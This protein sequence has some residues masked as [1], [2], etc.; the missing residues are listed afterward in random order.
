MQNH[1]VG[2]SNVFISMSLIKKKNLDTES[3]VLAK[4]KTGRVRTRIQT[5]VFT[6]SKATALSCLCD[7]VR[8]MMAGS[9]MQRGS[10]TQPRD[11]CGCPNDMVC[12]VRRWN[13]VFSPVVRGGQT[14]VGMPPTHCR[15]MKPVRLLLVSLGSRSLITLVGKLRQLPGHQG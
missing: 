12:Y 2:L 3:L 6:T 15:K 9:D 13:K 11:G 1:H 10:A 7:G 8:K 5:Q 14:H 4:E